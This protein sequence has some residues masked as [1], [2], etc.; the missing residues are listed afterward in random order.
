MDLL[1]LLAL[2]DVQLVVNPPECKDPYHPAGLYEQGTVT[3]CVRE[4]VNTTETIKHE[5]IHHGQACVGDGVL[6]EGVDYLTEDFPYLAY[7]PEEW[8]TEAEARVLAAELTNQ[9]LEWLLTWACSSPK[10]M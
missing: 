2:L 7:D 4:G 9:Q 1:L 6:R 3:V 10:E 5:L 8:E